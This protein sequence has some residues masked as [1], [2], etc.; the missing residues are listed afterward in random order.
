M[1]D[2]RDVGLMTVRLCPIDR[3][4]LRPRGVQ[5]MICVILDD[6]IVDMRSLWSTFG[7]RFDINYCHTHS[8]IGVDL[9]TL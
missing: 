6:V 5:H 7:P 1:T 8:P 9:C 2:P 4:L 3:L